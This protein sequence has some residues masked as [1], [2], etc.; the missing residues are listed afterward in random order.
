MNRVAFTTVTTGGTF[1]EKIRAMAEAGFTAT[2]LWARDLFE[3][4]E[5]PEVALRVLRDHGMAVCAL[6]AI[7]NF[8]GCAGP[9]RVLKLDIAR[10]MMDLAC[11][12]GTPTITLAA[13]VQASANG[14]TPRL[15]DDLA[16][17]ASEARSRGLRVAYEAIA[18]A[19]HVSG[20]DRALEL[21]ETVNDPA[22]GLQID[23]FHAYVRGHVRI[24]L[25][26]IPVERIFLVELADLPQCRLGARELSRDMRLFPGEGTAPLTGF[27]RDLRDIDYRGDVVVEVFNAAYRQQPPAIA[28]AQ[29]WR[30]MQAL[31]TPTRQQL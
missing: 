25:E 8:E 1:E 13:N 4:F 27:V 2:E 26:H 17:L 19:P 15:V 22:L 31:M 6:Q 29:A 30:S 5:G 12:A 24:A 14:S 28:A 16:C 23:V 10:R 21:V 18:W 3:N 20:F 7:R 9:E 11:L